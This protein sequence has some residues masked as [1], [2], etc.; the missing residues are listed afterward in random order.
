[1]Q[2]KESKGK[3]SLVSLGCPKNLVDAEVMLGYL[4]R[5][6]YEVTTDEREA[7][8]II[9][10]TCSFIKEA[11]QES[12]DTILDLA[13]RKHD[14]HCRLLIVTGCLPQRY[15]EELTK[16]LPEVDIFVG[17]GDYPRIAEIIAEQ[18]GV[19][20]QI[21][22]TG[23]PNFLY[24]D[25]FPRLKSSPY[26]SAYLKIAEGCSNC[27]SYCV[28]PTLRGSFRSRPFDKLLREAGELAA[29][30]VIELNLIAQ[31]ITAY[32]RDLANGESLEALIEELAKL[33]GVRWIRLL[34]AYPDGI[35]DSL[36][37]LIRDE[38]KVCK[39]LDIPLQH[40][41]DS[42]LKQMNRRSSEAEIRHLIEKL[43]AEIPGISLRTSLI[44][45]FPGETDEDFRKLLHF[46]EDTQFD[47]L[48]VF[49]YSREEGTTAAEMP[50]QVSERIK[51]ERYKKLMRAQTRVSFKRNRRLVNTMEQVIIE[52]YSEETELLLKGRSSLQAPDIDGQV[53]ITAGT[54]NVGDIVTL[55]I[56]DSS[57][58]DLI[59]EIV[60]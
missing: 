15:Q 46:V 32:G 59:G 1:M 18:R 22:Y 40:I 5:E 30:G 48:G 17:T 9:V 51:R 24:D 12:I 20:G 7:E 8:I 58:Y 4:A 36:V 55:R 21:R 42:I 10:N 50:E 45:G 13:D 11:K 19:G 53:Y 25:D 16:E 29:N 49:C 44:V 31:D 33:S 52:G 57:D 60:D 37:R 56:T 38:D 41:S 47:H 6:G 28:I 39:Y 27:C 35:R 23:N 3:V 54:A 43:R 34:Y 26:Y 2:N 14:G